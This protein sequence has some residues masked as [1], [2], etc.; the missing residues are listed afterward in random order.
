MKKMNLILILIMTMAI[1]FVTT[2]NAFM[3]MI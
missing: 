3:R 2:K 1:I